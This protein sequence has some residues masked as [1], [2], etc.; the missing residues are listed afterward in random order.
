MGSLWHVQL[1]KAILGRP[2][3]AACRAAI[4][5]AKANGLAGECL[6]SAI[7]NPHLE[8]IENVIFIRPKHPGELSDGL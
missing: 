2:S 1:F 5:W 4:E 8:L 3:E 7:F 6:S